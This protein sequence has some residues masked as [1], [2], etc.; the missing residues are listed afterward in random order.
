LLQ[1]FDPSS[2]HNQFWFGD[3]TTQDV[4][5]QTFIIAKIG[6]L[7]ESGRITYDCDSTD[8]SC[9]NGEFARAQGTDQEPWL[10]LCQPFWTTTSR[11]DSQFE[12]L[13]HELSHYVDTLDFESGAADTHQL[14]VD[15]PAAA[16]ANADSYGYFFVCAPGICGE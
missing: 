3:A 15:Y 4:Y 1:N 10:R 7:I 8:P 14:A 5:I 11:A 13:V 16:S 6:Q 9:G 12:V 2:P